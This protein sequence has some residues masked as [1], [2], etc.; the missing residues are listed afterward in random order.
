MTGATSFT[1]GNTARLNP[2]LRAARFRGICRST[3]RIAGDMTP[4]RIKRSELEVLIPLSDQLVRD[5]FEALVK[6]SDEQVQKVQT[7]TESLRLN[8]VEVSCTTFHD[9]RG[10]ASQTPHFFGVMVT[11]K[12]GWKWLT[13]GYRT[14]ACKG[15]RLEGENRIPMVGGDWE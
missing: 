3:F 13:L 7:V 5:R 6:L 9:T 1:S 10:E 12:I 2:F 15:F 4:I 14:L 8:D 11:M